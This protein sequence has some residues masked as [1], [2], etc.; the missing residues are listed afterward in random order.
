MVLDHLE[1]YP[2]LLVDWIGALFF[3]LFL[4]HTTAW[5]V[6]RST[7]DAD[8]IIEVDSISCYHP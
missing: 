8:V 1:L 2:G 3:R 5:V 7:I 4:A 6:D